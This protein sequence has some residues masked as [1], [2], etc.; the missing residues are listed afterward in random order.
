M[1]FLE[2]ILRLLG[3]RR[4][5]RRE[6]T[7]DAALDQSLRALA[8]EEDQPPRVVAE[9]LLSMALERRQHAD[10]NLA[11]WHSLTSRQKEVAAL[12]CLDYTNCEI[13]QRLYISPETVKTHIRNT[14]H[15]FGLHGKHEL[16]QALADWNFSAWEDIKL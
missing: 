9:N 6:Y 12:T 10:K 7:F 11:L 15:R 4:V 1:V 5:K 8:R 14:L 16:R 13:A 3:L 2:R